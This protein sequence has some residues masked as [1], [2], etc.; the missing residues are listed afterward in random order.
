MKSYDFEYSHWLSKKQGSAQL[1]DDSV[2]F[3]LDGQA[4]HIL[5]S[6]LASYKIE[7]YNGTTLH[8]RL[9]DKEK[10][11]ITANSN[12]CQSMPFQG[13]CDDLEDRLTQYE[14]HGNSSL[15]RKPG[16]FE[17]KSF[18]IVL[19]VMTIFLIL[20]IIYSLAVGGRLS[21]LLVPIGAFTMLWAAYFN[22]KKRRREKESAQS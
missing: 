6:Q 21:T 9:V 4:W 3:D 16:T 12:F 15:I 13:F 19:L 2:K 22:A 20:A 7:E 18:Y 5:F 11:K 14:R 1:D 10:L 8:L 17:Q